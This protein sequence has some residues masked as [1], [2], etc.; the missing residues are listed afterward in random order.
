VPFVDVLVNTTA[1]V[2]INAA[3]AYRRNCCRTRRTGNFFYLFQC[4]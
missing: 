1:A 2:Q 3:S 4:M